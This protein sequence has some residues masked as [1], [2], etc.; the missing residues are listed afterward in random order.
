[1]TAAK[2]A[3]ELIPNTATA[4][5]I[6]NSKLLLAAVKERVAVLAVVGPDLVAHVETDQEHHH[7]V[8]QERD[9]NPHDIQRDLHDQVALEAEHHDNRKQQGDQ[10]DGADL[11]NECPLVPLRPLAFTSTRRVSIPA[12]NGI[13]R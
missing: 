11:R 1:M 8:D 13:P 2:A 5:A 9:G 3:P 7:E 4:T 10:R 6:A 12:R